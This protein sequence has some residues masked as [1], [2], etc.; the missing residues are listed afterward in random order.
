MKDMGQVVFMYGSKVLAVR[1]YDPKQPVPRMG[2]FVVYEGYEYRVDRVTRDMDEGR[3]V[4]E[5][6]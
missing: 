4:V 5:V 6:R 2:E 1:P 3:V